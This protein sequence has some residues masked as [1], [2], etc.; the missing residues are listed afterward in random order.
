[1]FYQNAAPYVDFLLALV[2][3]LF[4]QWKG[5]PM[6][7]KFLLAL[8][9]T[10]SGAAMANQ[11]SLTVFTPWPAGSTNDVTC[12]ALFKAYGE[13][14][15]VNAV[16][17]NQ[18]GAD[19]MIAH[20]NFIQSQGP[21]LFCSGNGPVWNA[22][23]H[24]TTAPAMDTVR[25]VTGVIKLSFFLLTPVNGA[26][27]VDELVRNSNRTGKPVLVGALTQTS[28]RIMTSILDKQGAKYEV[29]V[30][31][32]NGEGLIGL[33]EGALDVYVDGGSI[34]LMGQEGYKEIAH[35]AVGGD[36]APTENLIKR[37]P[38]VE[39]YMGT[40]IMYARADTSDTELEDISAK[41]RAVINGAAMREYFRT[42]APFHTPMPMT[43]RQINAQLQ[44]LFKFLNAQQ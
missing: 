25:P 1:M 28:A 12:R 23:T 11:P 16:I 27:S 31:R 21:A 14:H 44:D 13:A 6:F 17:L 33:K 20:R 35:L 39:N 5:K 2:Y 7:K 18:P 37:W 41:L 10:I 43:P 29:V 9:L 3:N 22:V 40:V 4:L 30:Y 24:K 36:K 8:M 32:R 19:S 42:A 15:N 34:K 38:F 26:N